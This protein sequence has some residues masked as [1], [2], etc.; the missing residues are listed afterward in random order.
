[1]ARLERE[2]TRLTQE[3]AET[4]QLN[5][6][7][8][9]RIATLLRECRAAERQKLWVSDVTSRVKLTISGSVMVP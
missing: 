6:Q 7:L 9:E 1:M 2:Q 5:S 8:E 3:T 4:E